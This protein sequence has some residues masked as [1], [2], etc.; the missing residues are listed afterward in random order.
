MNIHKLIA[1][2]FIANPDNKR[3]VDH[4]DNDRLNNNIN[5]LRWC[6]QT[7]NSMNTSLY[8]NNSSGVKGVS[9][10][11]Q[12]NKWSVRITIDGKNTHIGY[13][14][15]IEEA[16]EVR[17]HQA[18]QAFGRFTNKCEGLLQKTILL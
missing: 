16:A 1:I 10:H 12:F 5:N 18:R 8:R 6:T 13:Y 2:A 14:D 9:W 7:E 17:L 4:I 3:C 11:K 15:T